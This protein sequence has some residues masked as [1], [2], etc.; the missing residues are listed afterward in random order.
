[1]TNPLR[2]V[3][4][5]EKFTLCLITS[6]ALAG[7]ISHPVVPVSEGAIDA[8]VEGDYIVKEGSKDLPKCLQG[9]A[10][11][12]LKAKKF[13]RVSYRFSSSKYR[14]STIAEAPGSGFAQAGVHVELIPG[15]CRKGEWAKIIR[16]LYA[17]PPS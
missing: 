11:E 9:M 10:S 15:D 3:R 4:F 8:F 17:H 6:L 2:I 12:E 1:M 7:C 16:P 14:V 13:V 5:A